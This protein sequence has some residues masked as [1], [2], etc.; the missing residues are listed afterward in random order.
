MN[1]KLSLLVSGVSH[2]LWLR[3]VNIFSLHSTPCYGVESEIKTGSHLMEG[4]RTT[5]LPLTCK[6][7]MSFPFTGIVLYYF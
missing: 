1:Y 3:K 4:D 5:Q 2:I 7:H 6:R